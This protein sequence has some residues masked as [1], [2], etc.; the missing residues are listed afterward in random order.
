M[1]GAWTDSHWSADRVELR[2]GDVLVLYS[3]GVTDTVGADGRFGE[4]RLLEALRGVDRRRRR[5]SRR[6][7]PR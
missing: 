3:D 7:T 2:A 4:E 1:L 6:S 5:R